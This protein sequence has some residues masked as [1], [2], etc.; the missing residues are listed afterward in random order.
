[1]VGFAG[2]R[3]AAASVELSVYHHDRRCH[4]IDTDVNGERTRGAEGVAG[5]VRVFVTCGWSGF[6]FF[7]FELG[8]EGFLSHKELW[9]RRFARA[10]CV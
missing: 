8:G 3:V 2:S 4:G 5:G 10:S 1:M 9:G 6:S 7:F